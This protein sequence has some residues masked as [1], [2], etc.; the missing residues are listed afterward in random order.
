MSNSFG[1]KEV[2]DV[3]TF[4]EHKGNPWASL[5]TFFTI[6]VSIQRATF[7][8]IKP[9]GNLSGIGRKVPAFGKT[10]GPRGSI[11]RYITPNGSCQLKC[12]E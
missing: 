6:C 10:F 7:D 4:S 2:R 9:L 11:S 5:P 3:E 1:S 8:N 12:M